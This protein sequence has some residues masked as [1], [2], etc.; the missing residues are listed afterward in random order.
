M[1][2]IAAPGPN[3]L[4][5]DLPGFPEPLDWAAAY[6][7]MLV[8]WLQA[9]I[10]TSILTPCGGIGGM[11]HALKF[12]GIPFRGNSWDIDPAVGPALRSI[13][14]SRVD[15]AVGPVLG[16]ILRLH[17]AQVPS[18]NLLAAGPP[19]PP[20]S[21]LGKGESYD[22]PRAEV[23]LRV[24]DMIVD[25]AKRERPAGWQHA[26]WGFVLENVEGI[27]NVSAV[28][29]ALGVEESPMEQIKSFLEEQLGD[30]WF[31]EITVLHTSD[32]GLP[33]KRSRAYLRGAR[34]DIITLQ[35]LPRPLPSLLR[36]GYDLGKLLRLDLPNT[37]KIAAG[38]GNK[39][40]SNLAK[41]K[42]MLRE[43]MRDLEFFGTFAVVD[44]SRDTERKFGAASRSD[45]RAPCL[46]ASNAKLWVFSLG[47]VPSDTSD[48]ALPEHRLPVDRWLHPVERFTLQGFPPDLPIAVRDAVRV[49]GNAMSTP[50]I[51]RQLVPIFAALSSRFL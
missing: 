32:Y 6:R 42:V 15:V 51:G 21:P 7:P 29:R 10:E 34:R 17:L 11:E 31:L 22:D 39:Y 20:W 4:M 43:H 2:F 16:D 25:Q 45:N 27:L 48:D 1:Q 35:P 47:A 9:G 26:F 36:G 33:Q 5:A 44:L 37:D 19:C 40:M 3:T 28:D 49:T 12:L 30:N 50:S 46:T 13:H 41:F 14:R 23:F 38:R 18:A 24:C 8:P